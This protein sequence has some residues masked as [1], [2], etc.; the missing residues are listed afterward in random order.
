MENK[1]KNVVLITICTILIIIALLLLGIRLYFRI[2]VKNYYN[3]SEKAFKIPGLNDGMV[4]QGLDYIEDEDLYLIGGY[5][6]DG[7][8]SRIYLVEKSTG[9]KKGYVVLADEAGNGINPHAGGLAVAN[10]YLFVTGDE[11][12][13][14]YVFNLEDVLNANSGDS[15]KTLG[16]FDTTFGE[17]GIRADFICAAEDKLIVGEFYRE[18]NYLT[19]DTHKTTNPNGEKSD[20]LALCFKYSNEE[21]SKFGLEVEPYEAYALPALTQGITVHN[22]LIY[23]SESYALAFSTVKAFNIEN[24]EAFSSIPVTNGNIPLY[25]LDSSTM[26]DSIKFPPMAE[27]I[28]FVEDKMLT[29]CESASQKYIFGNLTGAK[30]CYATNI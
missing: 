20:A 1:K 15:I 30:W 24:A 3:N 11:E 12:P 2:P 23:T 4:P 16:K 8:P 9:N 14:M 27:E 22:G 18:P 7:S 10:D 25:A 26:V 28:I 19:P 29:M 21:N 13:F 6:K 17:D 5:Q